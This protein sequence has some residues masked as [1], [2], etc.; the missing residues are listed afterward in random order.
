MAPEATEAGRGWRDT[1]AASA[2][3]TLAV[4]GSF[5]LPAI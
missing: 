1:A 4:P 3:A 2:A 5:S